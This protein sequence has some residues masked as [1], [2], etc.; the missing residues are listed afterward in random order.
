VKIPVVWGV[1]P[2]EVLEVFNI[3]TIRTMTLV[4]LMME[5][6][7]AFETSVNFY[8]TTR[9]N[10]PEDRHLHLKAKVVLLTKNYA[11]KA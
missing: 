10:V 11:V 4:T 5:T 2:C 7:S 3:S 1:V 6:V 8:E 9:R